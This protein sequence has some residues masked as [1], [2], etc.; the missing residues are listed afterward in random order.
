[1]PCPQPPQSGASLLLAPPTAYPTLPPPCPHVAPPPMHSLSTRQRAFAFN[2]PLSL[3]VSSVTSMY[4]MFGVRSARALHSASIAGPS[5]RAACTAA[6]SI[7]PPAFVLA[8]RRSSHAS[9]STPQETDLSDANKVLIRCAWSGSAAFASQY[10]SEWGRLGA[11]SPPLPPPSPPP[12]PP[13]LPPP[14]PPSPSP[15]RP[16]APPPSPPPPRSPT[17][18]P[19]W[20]PQQCVTTA[21][22]RSHCMS[23]PEGHSLTD[24]RMQ[25]M[26]KRHYRSPLS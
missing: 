15:P 8:C 2:Q 4:M 22:G 10:G 21:D 1:M 5:L 19:A 24:D 3:D 17:P 6:A 23:L 14:P 18:E 26:I 11:C 20:Q 9:R 13:S 16:S 7:C 25:A 12:P